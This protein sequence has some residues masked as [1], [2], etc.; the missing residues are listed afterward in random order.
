MI[1]MMITTR[2]MML[3]STFLDYD[4]PFCFSS[5]FSRYDNSEYAAR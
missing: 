3:D 1:T 4:F 5:P 2:M